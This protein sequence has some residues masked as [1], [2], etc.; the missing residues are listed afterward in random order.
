MVTMLEAARRASAGKPIIMKQP[1]PE[2]DGEWH[3]ELSLCVN[4]MVLC[5]DMDIF[6]DKKKKFAPEHK[7]TPYFRVQSMGS[8][9][10]DR[11][12]LTLRHHSVSGTDTK[13]GKWRIRS[14]DKI[15]CKKVR[16]GNLG[17][18]PNDS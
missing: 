12:D 2:W 13:W 6:E 5:E 17:L 1:P 10:S 4:D 3:Y 14:L 16:F 15:K 18:L 8:A 7:E 9:R 11:I